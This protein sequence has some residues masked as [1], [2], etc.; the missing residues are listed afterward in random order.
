M[1]PFEIISHILIY[2]F[3]QDATH[4]KNRNISALQKSLG[5]GAFENI[6]LELSIN[7]M[8]R[9]CTRI[10]LFMKRMVDA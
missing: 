5:Q 10:F 8:R 9:F 4:V 7:Y 2:Q 6:G 3:L 1:D